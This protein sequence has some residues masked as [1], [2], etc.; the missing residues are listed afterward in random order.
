MGDD[1]LYLQHIAEAVAKIERFA[2]AL[3]FE[4]F[5]GREMVQSAVMREPGIIGE[6][7]KKLSDEFKK[8]HPNVPWR[9]IAGMRDKLVHDYFEVDVG[10]VWQTLKEDIPFLKRELLA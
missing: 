2:D 1:N 5:S 10:A 3:S 9:Q 8:C 4:E 7:A 6:A